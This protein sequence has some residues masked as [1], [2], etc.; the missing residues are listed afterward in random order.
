MKYEVL[1]YI[2]ILLKYK[3][4]NIRSLLDKWGKDGD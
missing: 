3:F 4:E 2:K 1:I